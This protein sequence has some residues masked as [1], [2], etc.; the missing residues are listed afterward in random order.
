MK[1]TVLNALGGLSWLAGL[2]YAKGADF[3]LGTILVSDDHRL[4]VGLTCG[5][6]GL[7]LLL[8]ANIRSPA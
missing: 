7:L 8:W 3:P 4:A 6:F 1:W 5:L 2:E